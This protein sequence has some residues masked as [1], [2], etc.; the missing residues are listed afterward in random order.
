MRRQ[1]PIQN[2]SG[3]EIDKRDPLRH[4]GPDVGRVNGPKIIKS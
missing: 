2:E 4:R 3:L 1:R